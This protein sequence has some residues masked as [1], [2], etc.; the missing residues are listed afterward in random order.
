MLYRTLAPVSAGAWPNPHTRTYCTGPRARLPTHDG[1]A[2]RCPALCHIIE[3]CSSRPDPKHAAHSG[4][5]DRISLLRCPAALHCPQSTPLLLSANIWH[6]EPRETVIA[7]TPSLPSKRAYPTDPRKPADPTPQGPGASACG[8]AQP[9][10]PPAACRS[11]CRRLPW[12]R[13]PHVRRRPPPRVTAHPHA[14]GALQ[15]LSAQPRVPA[16]PP[17]DPGPGRPA[18]RGA[19]S[20]RAL[21]S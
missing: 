13:A 19:P 21:S 6:G 11:A 20:A 16:R 9:P 5:P 3:T 2:S 15:P 12:A 18:R 17:S 14:R 7:V 10:P 8:R 1:C 4:L